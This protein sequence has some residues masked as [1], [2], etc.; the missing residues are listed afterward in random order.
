M[1]LAIALAGC[2]GL[3][4]RMKIAPTVPRIGAAHVSV[5]KNVVGM[6]FWIWGVPGRESI[7]NVSAPKAIVPG[8]RR[9]GIL[10]CRKIP[11]SKGY[12]IARSRPTIPV[13]A[14]TIDF[15]KPDSSITFDSESL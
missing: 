15:E 12:M 8:I 9:F 3:T 1:P 6:M 13:T 10:L 2:R 11:A 5:L 14:K 4:I 7:V